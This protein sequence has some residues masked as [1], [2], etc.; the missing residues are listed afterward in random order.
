M[1]PP[2]LETHRLPKSARFVPATRREVKPLEHFQAKHACG[3]SD[4]GWTLVRRQKCDPVKANRAKPDSIDTGSRRLASGAESSR[5]G[6]V[7]APEL[8]GLPGLT[9]MVPH[10]RCCKC[11]SCLPHQ[12]RN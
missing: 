6:Q 3:I 11:S 1:R 7:A 2:T 9:M 4:P 12:L 8:P 5:H 10:E